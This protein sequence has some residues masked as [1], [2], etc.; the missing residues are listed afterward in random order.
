MVESKGLSDMVTSVYLLNKDMNAAKRKYDAARKD[1]HSKMSEDEITSHTVEVG[2]KAVTATLSAPE[3]KVVDIDKLWEE[4]SKTEDGKKV[5]FKCVSATQSSVKDNV[6]NLT[7]EKV[8]TTVK[9]KES[10]TVK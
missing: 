2:G 5:F 6:G 10:V 7:C 1:L 9:G 8:I 4:L 3:R